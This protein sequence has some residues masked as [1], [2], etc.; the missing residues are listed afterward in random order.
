MSYYNMHH[1]AFRSPTTVNYARNLLTLVDY[2]TLNKYF[3]S[4]YSYCV[5]VT[6]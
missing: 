4:D 1:L 6:G 5:M 3:H 2:A